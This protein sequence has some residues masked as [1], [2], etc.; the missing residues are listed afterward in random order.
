MGLE[1]VGFGFDEW[2]PGELGFKCVEFDVGEWVVDEPGMIVEGIVV[3]VV[4]GIAVW[5][6]QVLLCW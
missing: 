1:C 3:L 4:A 2:V 6:S 5:W